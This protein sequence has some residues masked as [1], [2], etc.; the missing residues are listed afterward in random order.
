MSGA[1]VFSMAPEKVHEA[2]EVLFGVETEVDTITSGLR[3]ETGSVA[4]AFANAHCAI[5]EALTTASDFWCVQRVLGF[6]GLV[7]N[8][9]E[10][11]AVCAEQAVEIDDFSAHDFATLADLDR[12]PGRAAENASARPD[13]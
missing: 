11:L 8:L 2:V 5:G 1:D 9:G 4:T 13:W 10:Y 3:A 6:T 12:Y 7:G